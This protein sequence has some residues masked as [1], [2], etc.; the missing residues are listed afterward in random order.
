MNNDECKAGDQPG[1]FN[2]AKR[3]FKSGKPMKYLGKTRQIR[4]LD[5]LEC[6]P[7][8]LDL[9]HDDRNPKGRQ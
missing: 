8:Q 4:L 1:L 5:G 6:D 7:D 2:E 9:F 3:S